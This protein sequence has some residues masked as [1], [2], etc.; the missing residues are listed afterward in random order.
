MPTKSTKEIF[1]KAGRFYS[2]KNKAC[3]VIDDI[4]KD[5]LFTIVLSAESEYLPHTEKDPANVF[6]EAEGKKMFLLVSEFITPNDILKCIS[7]FIY[8]YDTD[9]SHTHNL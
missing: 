4:L 5:G 1:E 7:K 6:I 8:K 3:D 2:E 9:Y